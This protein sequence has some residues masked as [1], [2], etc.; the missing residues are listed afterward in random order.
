MDNALW[1]AK[2]GLEAHHK[3]INIISNNLANANTNGFK[4]NRAEFEDLLYHVIRQPGAAS[5]EETNYPSGI[6]LGT[7]V[8]LAANRKIFTDGA[9]IQ[10]DNALDVSIAG[11]GFLRVEI[12]G[13]A[14]PVYTRS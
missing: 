7:G 10:T 4:K 6:A 11:R 8:K 14:D 13:Q 9:P 12:P 1:T 5:T 3:N 2:S